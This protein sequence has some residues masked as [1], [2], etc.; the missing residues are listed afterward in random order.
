MDKFLVYI[1]VVIAIFALAIAAYV[2][3]VMGSGNKT[4]TITQNSSGT[5]TYGPGYEIV[6][7]SNAYANVNSSTFNCNSAS[8]CVLVHTQKCFNNL[9]LQQACIN[10]SDY[11][12]YE[13]AYANYT[14][15]GTVCPQ[16]ILAGQAGCS[17]ISNGCNLEF[18]KT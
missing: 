6:N 16:F 2:L 1:A 8:D 5:Q 3:N 14:R 18:T 12:A 7:V 15:N 17:C 4:T 13:S 11:D 10:V 9:P